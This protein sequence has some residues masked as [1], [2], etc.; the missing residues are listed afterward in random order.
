MDD[1]GLTMGVGCRQMDRAINALPMRDTPSP[2]RREGWG[3]GESAVWLVTLACGPLSLTL[4][5]EGGG[6]ARLEAAAVL[7]L[8]QHPLVGKKDAIASATNTPSPLTGEGWGEGEQRTVASADD[9]STP[10]LALVKLLATRLSPQAGKSMVIP[11]QGGGNH[12]WE[13]RPRGDA[14]LG[15]PQTFDRGE[16]AAPTNTP[17]PLREEGGGLPATCPLAGLVEWLVVPSGGE[18]CPV[19][20]NDA[21]QCAKRG[22]A[23][24]AGLPQNHHVIPAEARIHRIQ[25]AEVIPH[26]SH[27]QNQR[28]LKPCAA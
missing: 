18:Q 7:P 19:A 15:A 20:M 6:D 9:G 10:T 23:P 12:L 8:F 4:P 5:R 16:G 13:P 22:I 24:R 17:S 28:N 14:G 3:G 11:P 25:P 26:L 2:L 27:K 21:W 1:G